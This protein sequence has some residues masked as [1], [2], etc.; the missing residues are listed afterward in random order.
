[1]DFEKFPKIPRF[2]RDI[3]ITEKIDGTNGQII[4]ERFSNELLTNEG[5]GVM[6][7]AVYYQHDFNTDFETAIWAGS[8]NRWL[9]RVGG[10]NHG[11]A[12]WVFAN[13]PELVE[14]LGVGRHYGEWWG[15]GI[16]RRYGLDHKR[17]SLFNTKRWAT[18]ERPKCCDAVPVIYEGPWMLPDTAILAPNMALSLL[19]ERGSFAAPGYTEPE[20]IVIFHP[21]GNLTFKITLEGDQAGKGYEAVS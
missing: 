1:M 12:G 18:Q 21:Q 2:N 7:G 19:L 3:I 15:Q 4:I 10:D 16:G 8:R 17:F 11:F 20:G 9:N 14:G 5:R 6:A 13:G